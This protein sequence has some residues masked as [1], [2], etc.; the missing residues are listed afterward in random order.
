MGKKY[1]TMCKI[2]VDNLPCKAGYAIMEPLE[3]TQ[4]KERAYVL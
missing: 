2:S 4:K 3:Q 1:G